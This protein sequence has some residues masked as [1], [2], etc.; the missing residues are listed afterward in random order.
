MKKY[1]I[2]IYHERFDIADSEWA[3]SFTCL[4]GNKPECRHIVSETFPDLIEEMSRI[5]L[6]HESK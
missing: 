6:E 5:L 4:C 1:E 3:A 2:T